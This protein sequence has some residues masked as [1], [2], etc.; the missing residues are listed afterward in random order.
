MQK[1]Y[2]KLVSIGVIV[3][4][5][6]AAVFVQPSFFNKGIDFANEKLSLSLPHIPEKEFMLGLDLQGGAELLYEADLSGLDPDT[7][8][9]AMDGLRDVIER[10]INTLGVREPE[11][12]AVISG[13]SYRLKV[14]IPGITDP[15]EAIKEI[16]RTPYLEFQELKD[17]YEEIQEKNQLVEETG[18]GEMENFFQP[19]ELTGQYLEAAGIAFD[20]NTNQPYITLQFNEQG[21]KLFEEIT[22]RNIEKP[23]AMSID[24]EILSA[25]NV[26]EQISGGTAQITGEFTTEEAKFLARNLNAGAL[27]VPI[28]EPISMMTVGPT[29][30]MVSLQKSLKAGFFGI[31]AIIAFL[32]IIYRLPGLLAS[33]ALL[34]YGV[35]LLALFKLG[36]F[37][38]TLSGIGGFILS[39]GM[40]VDANILIFSRMREEIR[41]GKDLV[42]SVDEGFKRAW[43][44]IRDGNLTTLMVGLILF[45]VGTSFVQGFAT[46]LCLGILISMFSAVFVSR[47]FLM[48]LAGTRLS[49]IKKLWL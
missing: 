10:R 33:I 1:H 19:T 3:L 47:S 35:L 37:T 40:A 4:A 7:Y 12:E 5:I 18:E 39:L 9:Q 49:K 28:G 20:S 2:Y 29:L 24:G 6:I 38:L 27:P 17:N 46:T 21:A 41:S 45:G 30:G 36:S 14:R 42:I 34:I 26:S 32:I 8:S 16:G 23:L 22:G 43:T 44:S 31:L 48:V 13:D 15:Q 25:P 11:V